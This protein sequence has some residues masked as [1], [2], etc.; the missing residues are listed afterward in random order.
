VLIGLTELKTYQVTSRGGEIGRV[1]DVVFP[2]GEWVVRYIV[3]RSDEL[4]R[5]IILPCSCLEQANR[6]KRLL[7]ADVERSQVE[8]SPDLDLTKQIEHREEQDLY[9]CYGWPPYWLQEEQ[10]VT[11]TGALSGEPEQTGGPDQAE[12]SS[13]ELQLATD[14]VGAYAV[15]AHEGEFGVLQDIAVDD[16]T[17]MIP[18]LVVDAPAKHSCIL[19]ETDRVSEV[20]WVTKEVYVSLPA[21]MLLDSPVYHSQEPLTPELERSLHEYYDRIRRIT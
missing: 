2:R 16:Q 3:V 19:V 7:E 4:E 14:L 20:D 11:P 10:D 12:F 9:E 15:H 6:R 5:K 17:W 8:A 21:D 18:Y 1:A 13:P